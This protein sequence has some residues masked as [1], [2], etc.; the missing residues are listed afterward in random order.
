M[1]DMAERIGVSRR[2]LY[3]WERN[4]TTPRVDQLLDWAAT[5]GFDV[6]FFLSDLPG[7]GSG[8]AV[9]SRSTGAAAPLAELAA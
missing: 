1:A 9:T 8:D 5:T 2:T 4:K 3:S 7:C 6:D